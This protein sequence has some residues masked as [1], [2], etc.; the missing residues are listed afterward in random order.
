[1]M[2]LLKISKEVFMEELDHHVFAS[3]SLHQVVDENYLQF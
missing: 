3:L 2:S 1:M